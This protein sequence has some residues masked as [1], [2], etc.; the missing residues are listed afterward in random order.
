MDPETSHDLITLLLKNYSFFLPTYYPEESLKQTIFSKE[1]RTPIGLAAG[2]D[3][4]GDSFS[5]LNALGF[6]YYE[7]GSFTLKSQMGNPRPRIKRIISQ[8]ALVNKMGFNNPG[9]EQG[10]QNIKKSLSKKLKLS[11]FIGISL[12]R[13]KTTGNQNILEEYQEM[14]AH[15]DREENKDIHGKTLYIV[16]NVSSPNTPGLR[17]LQKKKRPLPYH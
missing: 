4:Y 10:I 8:R 6:G 13:S 3:K 15:I 2:F 9:I 16:I 12:G 1:I 14:L 5:S 7:L 11:P 17:E